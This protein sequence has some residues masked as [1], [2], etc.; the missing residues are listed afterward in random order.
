MA[1]TGRY[2]AHAPAMGPFTTFEV[3]ARPLRSDPMW[4]NYPIWQNNYTGFS[5]LYLH[6]YKGDTTTTRLDSRRN[7]ASKPVSPSSYIPNGG[8]AETNVL[9]LFESYR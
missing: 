3:E 1:G 7:H 8:W 2:I 6:H 4:I 5:V 9:G